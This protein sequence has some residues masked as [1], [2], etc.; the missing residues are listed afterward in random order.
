M[1]HHHC[2]FC[3]LLC[4]S[5]PGLSQHISGKPDCWAK[6]KASLGLTAPPPANKK[7]APVTAEKTTVE[8]VSFQPFGDKVNRKKRKAASVEGV[9]ADRAGKSDNRR[10][11]ADDDWQIVDSCYLNPH[12]DWEI[13]DPFSPEKADDLEDNRKMP[14]KEPSF[15]DL[16]DDEEGKRPGWVDQDA[17]F[18]AEA[19]KDLA[20]SRAEVRAFMEYDNV[21]L[22]PTLAHARRQQQHEVALA[23]LLDDD[24]NNDKVINA[25]PNTAMRDG[26]R[27][28]TEAAHKIF[29]KDLTKAQKQGI[30]LLD[31]LQ[32]KK[33]SLDTYG[34]V[35]D[36]HYREKG[37]LKPD[38]TLKDVRGHLSRDVL[39]AT[40]KQRYNM[41]TKFPKSVPLKLPVSNALVNVIVHSAWDCLESLLTDPRVKDDDYNFVD[42]DPFKPPQRSDYIGDFHTARAHTEAYS[43]YI[44][45]PTRQILMP[46]LFY[47]DGAC[48]GQ[49]QNLP[50]TALKMALGIHTRKYRDNEHAW[51]SLG[52]VPQ[53]SKANSRGKALF[54]QSEHMDAEV[55]DIIDGEGQE[56][57]TNKVNKAQ[58]FHAI[59][60][61]ILKS[62]LEVQENGFV[63]D[64]RHAG[65]TYK[66]VEF[67]PYVVFVRCDTDE[68]D[69]LCGKFKARTS[70]V[71]NLCR[72]C[73]CPTNESDLV[74]AKFPYKT[75]SMIKPVIISNN[76]E[77]LRAISQQLIDNAFY[78]IRFS[79]ESS[80]GIHGATPSEMLHAILLGI[81]K[82][83]RNMF[84]EQ[85][86]ESSR[87]A[88]EI[89][90]LSQ[91][92]G[93]Q[94]GRQSGRDLPKCKFTQGIRRGKLQAKEFRGIL[95]VMAAV[96][97]SD[98]GVTLLK[99]NK[100]FREDYVIKD[101]L[102]LVEMVLEWEAFLCEHQM[103]K[104]HVMRLQKKN[105]FIMYLLKKVGKRS[106]GMGL[107]LMKFH[108]LVH[109]AE[110][111]ILFGI[112][113]EVDTGFNES[114]HKKTKVAARL[115]QKDESTFDLQTC[116]RLDEFET[117]ELAMLEVNGRK[118]W[119]YYNKPADPPRPKAVVPDEAISTGGCRIWVN[120]TEDTKE[121]CY[122]LGKTMQK[123]PSSTYWGGDVNRF[124]LELQE[125]L[126]TAKYLAGHLEIKGQ[127]KRNG[128][129]FRG[130]PQ[131][132]G[133]FWR[134]WVMIDWGEES[135]P[136]QIWCFVVVNCI[137]TRPGG[138][139]DGPL[140]ED[141]S[142][143][144][145]GDIE[146]QNGVYAVV[147]SS[148]YETDKHKVG[149]SDLFL[150]IRK[151]VKQVGSDTRP[152]KRK[153]YL[154]DVEAFQKP[155][156]VVP[157]IGGK[158]RRDYFIVKQRSEWVEMFKDWLD[159]PPANDVIGDEEPIPSHVM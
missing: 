8:S 140:V 68:G 86:G 141:P 61:V 34:A 84:F 45:D 109:L 112:P 6:H 23:G 142:G 97:R 127:H 118:L 52:F 107:K 113:L 44:T 48:T 122:C 119:N 106:T 74:N 76:E 32:K 129:V 50:I 151:D 134:D 130:H 40:I 137:P 69:E 18:E 153:F 125:K 17:Y 7:K 42:G 9:A 100:N 26:F 77:A 65:R 49:M 71:K 67:V 102:L 111:I 33:A 31:L 104:K 12:D 63:W 54:T 60:E 30:K 135:L 93:V 155:I 90:A 150:P 28:Y 11:E 114:H 70:G 136:G 108:V 139:Q 15:H 24:W 51:R 159:D 46:F 72:Y 56:S 1:P 10:G 83:V 55:E 121:P 92:Y 16:S 36:W 22:N 120:R 103:I 4:R 128:H 39:M 82:Y 148:K 89:N 158:S 58:D 43:K 116:T 62:Y 88:D 87:L 47:I 29:M 37:H 147:E 95:L 149:R 64:L 81:F 145:H 131:Y 13:V 14:A 110:D 115:T 85:I 20:Q 126:T 143:L 21:P 123:A 132:R 59:L 78:K 73:T 105:R 3:G 154:A 157:N 124:L 156:V 19:A 5:K 41:K 144:F 25:S 2:P 75:V 94:F 35:M 133:H 38:E 146:L 57:A 98:L 152:W 27:A 101:W 79:P 96:L 138:N 99:Q 91:K 53:V 117:I 80:R 66:D